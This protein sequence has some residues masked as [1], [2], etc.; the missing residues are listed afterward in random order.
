MPRVETGCGKRRRR[1]DQY[2]EDSASPSMDAF[3]EQLEKDLYHCL[4]HSI[5]C[6]AAFPYFLSKE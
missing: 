2:G 1:E 4:T 6:L 3:Y 5:I